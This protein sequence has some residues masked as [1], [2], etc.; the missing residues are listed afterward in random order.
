MAADNKYASTRLYFAQAK[1]NQAK[2][3]DIKALRN[4]VNIIYD[5]DTKLKSVKI[6]GRILLEETVLKLMTII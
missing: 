6:D 1:Y 4:A 3:T 5:T 2:S